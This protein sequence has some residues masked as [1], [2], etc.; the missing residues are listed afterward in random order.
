MTASRK[1]EI[2]AQL[3]GILNELI[4]VD[5][6]EEVTE[7]SPDTVEMLTIKES[8]EVVKGLS[9]HTIRK[10]IHQGKLLYVRTGEG[11]NGK[12][13]INKVDL[14]AFFN[15]QQTMRSAC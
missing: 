11:V 9:E 14:L 5:D 6:S 3:V 13:L 7:I 15:K 4:E 8:T 10:L 2:I 12:I 1:N